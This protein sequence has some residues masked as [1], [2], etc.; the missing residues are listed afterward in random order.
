MASTDLVQKHRLSVTDYR[1][2]GEA[3]ILRED[4]RVELIEGEIIDMSPIGSTHSGTL[5]RL[6]QLFHL[7]VGQSAVLSIQDPIVLG[8]HCEPQPD[9]ALLRPRADVYTSSRPRPEDCCCW[10]KSANRRSATIVRSSFRSMPGMASRRC[11]WW[12]WISS[13]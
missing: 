1:R 11:G 2:M 8:T 6:I 4:A 3:G 9:L 10:S 5:K 12:T 7:A 13:G